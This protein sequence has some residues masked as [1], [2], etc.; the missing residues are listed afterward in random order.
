MNRS[1]AILSVVGV[2]ITLAGV[3]FTLQGIGLLKGSSMTGTT[4]W[5]ILG[6]IIAVAGLSLLLIG[7]RAR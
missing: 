3:I 4:E 2:L 7:Q 6:P 5:T 1:R